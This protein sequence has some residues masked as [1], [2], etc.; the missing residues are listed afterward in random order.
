MF[1]LCVVLSFHFICLL[2][3]FNICFYYFNST[4]WR[5]IG[6]RMSR[7]NYAIPWFKWRFFSR[8]MKSWMNG[9]RIDFCSI[10]HDKWIEL[11]AGNLFVCVFLSIAVKKKIIIMQ[12]ALQFL[13]FYCSKVS[14][15]MSS[16]RLIIK[17]IDNFH[18]YNALILNYLNR[19][20]EKGTKTNRK[21]CF[22]T[23]SKY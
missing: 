13:L 11:K 15:L 5:F 23:N 2:T 9:F 10:V 22:I 4:Q 14:I 1:L 18:I 21:L 6:H 3:Q 19:I 7:V 20:D 16:S 12:L 17:S 8:W